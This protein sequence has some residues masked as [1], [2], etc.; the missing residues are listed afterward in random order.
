MSFVGSNIGGDHLMR[1]EL[2]RRI[3]QLQQE[4]I[5]H[6][7][8][9]Y[10]VTLEDNI[11]YLAN[12]TYQP[13]ERPFFIIIAPDK[14][15]V[16]I[17]PK[18]EERHLGKIII[19]CEIKAYWEYPS[20]EGENWFDIVNEA[21]KGYHRVG[22]ENDIK[23]G[24]LARLSAGEIIPADLVSDL[25]QIKSPYELQMIKKTAGICDRSM[26]TIFHNAYKGASVVEMFTLS[27]SVQQ[28]QIKSKDFDPILTKLLTAVWPAP[29]SSMPH[30]IPDLA[31]QVNQGPNVAMCYFRINGY[32][33]ECERTFFMG[34]PDQERQEHY[35]HMMNARNKA[36]AIVKAGVKCSDIDSEAKNYLIKNGYESRLLH[37][38][39]HG[40]GLG[41]HE[42]PWIAEGNDE[43]LKAN[44]V[45]SIEPAIYI[46]EI[47]GFRHSDTVLVTNE[48]YELLTKFP[49]SLEDMT[50][51]KSNRM[52]QLK[53]AIIKKALNL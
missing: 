25:R 41:N 1:E 18:L 36:L 46:E 19:D 29:A 4:I 3:K 31:D 17:V 8:D 27:K 45:I 51:L 42:E 13:E 50:I 49:V 10:I 6:N 15:P 9:A 30:S 35:R 44:M 20:P 34:R 26:E 47:G 33:A 53:G 52:A 5:R 37:R 16:L 40:I 21:V 48:G 14:L 23:A 43:I 11:W 2:I 39:G 22:V 28:E 24:I 38:T 12:V 32:A 7:L